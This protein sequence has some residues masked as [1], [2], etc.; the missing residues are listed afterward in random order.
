[1]IGILEEETID[2]STFDILKDEEVNS[3]VISVG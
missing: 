2:F 3:L 1:M